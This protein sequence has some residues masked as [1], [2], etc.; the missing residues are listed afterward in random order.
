[1]LNS[2]IKNTSYNYD[3]YFCIVV[4]INNACGNNNGYFKEKGFAA[5]SLKLLYFNSKISNKYDRAIIESA[6]WDVFESFRCE[7]LWA[8]TSAYHFP[9]K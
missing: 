5:I 9:F 6:K 2:K 1:M 7:K 8:K 4:K 3:R